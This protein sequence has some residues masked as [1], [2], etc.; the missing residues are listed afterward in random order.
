MAKTPRAAHNRPELAAVY[1]A[2]GRQC[3][4]AV[5]R[6]AVR[7]LI[8]AGISWHG[9]SFFNRL[10]VD[11]ESRF[12]GHVYKMR[13]FEHIR[14]LVLKKRHF[15]NMKRP[16]PRFSRVQKCGRGFSYG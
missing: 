13:F 15:F 1:Q 7:G 6:A 14:R 8:V 16:R 12:S 2:G 11:Y 4:P 5:R 9:L 3:P 10:Y